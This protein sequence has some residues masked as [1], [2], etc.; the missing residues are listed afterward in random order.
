MY[1]SIFIVVIVVVI[2]VVVIVV[3][4]VVVVDRVNTIFFLYQNLECALGITN[5]VYCFVIS[6]NAV[7]VI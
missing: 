5:F 2:I 3:V 1:Y 4:V 6:D 7:N